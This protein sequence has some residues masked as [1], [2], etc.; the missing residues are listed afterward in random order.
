MGLLMRRAQGVD[1]GRD[2]LRRALS[3]DPSPSV[4]VAAAEA[5]GRYGNADDVDLALSSLAQLSRPVENNYYV[6]L[7]ALAAIDALGSKAAPLADHLASLPDVRQWSPP[8]GEGY[9]QNLA[10]RILANLGRSDE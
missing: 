10:T 4:R 3:S 7:L 1:A 9:V 8:R 6:A 2:A 5:L